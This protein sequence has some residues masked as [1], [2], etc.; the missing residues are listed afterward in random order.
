MVK[1]YSPK[2]TTKKTVKQVK[3]FSVDALDVYGQGVCRHHQPIAFIEG[4]LPGE[5]CEAQIIAT[6]K[7]HVQAKVKKITQPAEARLKPFCPVFDTCGG[8]QLQ[9]VESAAALSWRQAAIADYWNKHLNLKNIPW[10]PPVTGDKPAYRRKTRLAVDARNPNN[11]KLGFRQQGSKSIVDVK[12]CPILVESLSK[13]IQPLKDMLSSQT[14]RTNI[15]HI[16]LLAGENIELIQVKLTRSVSNSFVNALI[17]FANVQKVNVSLEDANGNVEA[18]V[19]HE[20]LHCRLDEGCYLTP[21]ANDFVQVNDTVNQKMIA[22]AI[23]WLALDETQVIADL[24]CGLGNFSLPLARQVNKV[25]AVEGVAQM[26]QRGQ[27]NA[28]E[29][30]INNIQWQLG[31]LNDKALVRSVLATT[32]DAIVLDPSREGALEVCKAISDLSITKIL[33]VS[34]NPTTFARDATLL[35]QQGYRMEKV[36]LIEMF[37]FTKH[38]ELMALFI[39]PMSK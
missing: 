14:S 39:S 35:L 22:Q 4:G 32:L 9:H 34:C 18:L 29:Q 31:D 21:G 36:S 15:G 10:L 25:L 17:N 19:E 11:F 16:S 8:C 37:P 12:S 38:L 33:Y 3:N 1:F 2:K 26:V 5:V 20:K 6:H 13:L 24:F 23:N 27:T 28:Q 7:S 30:G